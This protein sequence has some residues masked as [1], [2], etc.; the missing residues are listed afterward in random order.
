MKPVYSLIIVLFIFSTLI[1]SA[2][3]LSVERW[4]RLGIHFEASEEIYSQNP[5][6][7]LGASAEI[8]GH[9]SNLLNIHFPSD[10]VEGFRD[11]YFNIIFEKTSKTD[12]VFYPPGLY[13]KRE[14]KEWIIVLN[15]SILGSQNYLRLITHEFFHAL[16]FYH[17]ENEEDW[18]REGLAQ[19]FEYHV[20]KSFNQAHLVSAL[21]RNNHSFISTFDIQKYDPEKYG[22]SLLFFIYFEK[23]C[24]DSAFI[25]N[26][27]RLKI[28]GP[29]GIDSYLKIYSLNKNYCQSFHAVSKSFALARSLNS[30]TGYEQSSQYFIFHSNS[31][32]VTRDSLEVDLLKN[33]PPY[34]SVRIPSTLARSIDLRPLNLEL[35]ALNKGFPYSLRQIS[36]KDLE[37]L[38]PQ[39][40]VLILPVTFA[41]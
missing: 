24:A 16:H 13:Q 1:A 27:L 39:Y 35:Y 14:A 12:A 36:L 10:L 34:L 7:F 32:P 37:T 9:I 19:L 17:Q 22:A 5:Q 8:S 20:H 26:F 33:L 18:V 25:W 40:D 2:R 23:Q 41:D 21:E 29:T 11:E 6:L 4:Q 15:P 31:S 3:D 38:A 28:S 30:Y